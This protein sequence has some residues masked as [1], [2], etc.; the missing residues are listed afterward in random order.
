MTTMRIYV[1]SSFEN[2]VQRAAVS[3]LR[4]AGHRVFDFRSPFGE[5][6][7]WKPKLFPEG[8][9]SS[10]QYKAALAHDE[11]Q[12]WFS[13]F[14]DA[15]I[16]SDAVAFVGPAGPSSG[17]ELGF[18]IGR[19]KRTVAL[20]TGDTP[21]DLMFLSCDYI[22]TDLYEMVTWLGSDSLPRR[23]KLKNINCAFDQYR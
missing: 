22:A 23:H 6:M 11:A 4:E 21:V 13:I 1:A 5:E 15:L 12:H 20:F 17:I 18:A 14:M 9:A 19:G 2:E 10:A 16:L 8:P 7:R 3:A